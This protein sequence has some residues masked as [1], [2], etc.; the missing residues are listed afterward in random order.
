MR[1]LKGMTGLPT[2]CSDVQSG[3][4][5]G[6]PKNREV[7]GHG[8]IVVVGPGEG[9]GQGEGPQD[10]RVRTA[11]RARCTSA[12][13]ERHPAVGMRKPIWKATCMESVHAWFGEGR[14]EKGRV[15]GTSLA[16]YSTV[17]GPHVTNLLRVSLW[18]YSIE[19][20]RASQAVSLHIMLLPTTFSS[21]VQESSFFCGLACVPGL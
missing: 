21:V 16:A 1:L 6:W 9:P 4:N 10:R 7:H 5:T 15:N 2:E 8:A 18:F 19:N 11:R 3:R 14:R 12:T 17:L 20:E 13:T